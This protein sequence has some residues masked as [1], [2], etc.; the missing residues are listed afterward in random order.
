MHRDGGVRVCARVKEYVCAHRGGG[1]H[2]CAQ[3]WKSMC[4]CV[5]RGGRVCV[6]T[7]VEESMRLHCDSVSKIL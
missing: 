1:V 6:C 2:V 5:Y 7:G 3:G 4:V